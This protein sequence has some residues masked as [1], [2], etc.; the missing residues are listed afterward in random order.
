MANKICTSAH[1]DIS[2]FYLYSELAILKIEQLACYGAFGH[3]PMHMLRFERN[4]LKQ[5]CSGSSG[6]FSFQW[7]LA[8]LGNLYFSCTLRS[9]LIFSLCQLPRQAVGAL[10]MLPPEDSISEWGSGY[11][12]IVLL[13]TMMKLYY[14]ILHMLCIWATVHWKWVFARKLVLKI[15][16]SQNFTCNLLILAHGRRRVSWVMWRHFVHYS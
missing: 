3:L 9:L 1:Q 16:K 11:M 13:D 15:S 2:W 12:K 4:T 6:H 5:V 8:F 7:W 10:P 14:Q